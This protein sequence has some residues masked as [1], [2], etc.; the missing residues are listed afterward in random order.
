MKK[1]QIFILA[2]D[3]PLYRKALRKILETPKQLRTIFEAGSGQEAI[4]LIEK[5]PIDLLFLDYSMPGLNGY[6][7]A[8]LILERDPGK[9]IIILTQYD[10]IPVI[11]NFF[12]IGAKGFLTKNADEKEILESIDAVTAGNYYY[13]SRFDATI[14]RWLADG[15]NKSVPAIKFSGRDMELV[16]LLSKGRTSQEISAQMGF[17]LRSIETYR[18]NLLKSTG[19]KNTGELLNYVYKN[20][21]V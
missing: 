5:H 4:A 13:H 17:S 7:T 15:L 20:G 9:K 1:K 6:D 14:T 3:H 21:I 10:E 2:D 19:V 8:K 12:K 18:Y 16:V 11:L